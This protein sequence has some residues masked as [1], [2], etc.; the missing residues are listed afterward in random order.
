METGAIDSVGTGSTNCDACIKGKTRQS[1]RGSPSKAK[2]PGHRY[3]DVTGLVQLASHSDH[4]YFVVV[5]DEYSRQIDVQLV[6]KKSEAS[7]FLMQFMKRFEH[8]TGNLIKAL[9]TG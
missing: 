8:M 6:Q 1:F 9:H 7:D 4:R 2:E 5:V 3:S